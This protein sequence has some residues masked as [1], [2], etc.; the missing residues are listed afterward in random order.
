M[1]C[2]TSKGHRMSTIEIRQLSQDDMPL[3]LEW[4]E[5]VLRDVFELPASYDMSELMERNR[6]FYQQHLADGSHIGGLALR[7]GQPVGCGAVCLYDEMPSPDNHS[8]VC[9]YLMNVYTV[10]DARHSGVAETVVRWL[11]AQAQAAGAGKIYLETTEAARHL[12][13]QQGFEPMVDYL[14]L[15]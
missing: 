5:R 6:A 2:P 13:Q 4:R 3:L 9:A 14:V 7:D 11:V 15:P 12:Y 8:G 10:P 1:R